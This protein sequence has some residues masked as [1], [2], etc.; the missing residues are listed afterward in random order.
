MPEEK[1]N[2]IWDIYTKNREKAGYTRRRGDRLE[3]GEFH[4]VANVCIFNSKNQ[5]LIQQRQPFKKGWPNMWA[6]SA[7]G[8][9]VAGDCS[10]QAAEREAWEELGLKLDLSDARPDFT[11]YGD[12]SFNDYYIVEQDVDLTRLHLQ[13]EE[14]KAVRWADREEVLK[15]QEQGLMIPRWFLGQLFEIRQWYDAHGKECHKVQIDFA[16]MKNLAAWMNLVEIMRD[17]F[18]GL[19]T[20]EKWE[21]YQRTVEKNIQRGTAI[22]AV[23]GYMLVGVLLFSTEQNRLSFMAVHPEFRRRG[24]AT[25]MIRLMYTKMNRSRDIVLETFRE[26][27]ERG[28]APRALYQSLGFEPEELCVFDN[29]YEMQRFILKAEQKGR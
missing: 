15:M 20:E 29:Q 23:D 18:P 17:H 6:L 24:I 14:V 3:K 25:E 26:G 22:C 28:T 10:Y 5:L 7:G 19:E 1:G 16:A 11:I 12:H 2:E 8:S 27:D 13:E 21:D 9:A 4:M